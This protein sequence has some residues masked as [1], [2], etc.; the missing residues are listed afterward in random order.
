MEKPRCHKI[1]KFLNVIDLESSNF[2]ADG[3]RSDD[4]YKV[5]CNIADDLSRQGFVVFVS[6]HEVVRKEL[7]KSA[8]DVRVCYPTIGIRDD[9]VYKLRG[10]YV[11]SV[12][13]SYPIFGQEQDKNFKAYANA[14]EQYEENINSL[15]K[16]GFEKMEIDSFDYS[17]LEMFDNYL[18][19]SQD[20][21]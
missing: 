21:S 16:S 6:S 11:Q 10:R 7:L 3:K 4:W 1:Q 5:Y 20:E 19:K 18:K 17:L 8:E 2:F 12:H 15:S 14:A 13:R 9:W